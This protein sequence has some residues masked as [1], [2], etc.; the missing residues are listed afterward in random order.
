MAPP[1]DRACGDAVTPEAA[2]CCESSSGAFQWVGDER[3][4]GGALS[5]VTDAIPLSAQD[6]AILGLEGRVL[7]GHTCKVIELAA[8][9]PSFDQL[10][11]RVAE[12]IPAVPA[13]AMRLGTAGGH[14]AWV[15]DLGF[16]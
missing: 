10:Q 9:A 2:G 1:L 7:V 11:A 13:L 15:P 14:P 3:E 12:R 8:P 4:R 16:A 5:G 6:E